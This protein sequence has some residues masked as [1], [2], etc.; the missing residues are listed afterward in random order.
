MF[1]H[2][3]TAL[4]GAWL[5]FFVNGAV[6]S[7]WAPR[8]PSVAA[9]LRLPDSELGIALL[10]VAAG[11]MPALLLT[12]RLLR[13]VSETRVSLCSGAVF[14]ALLPSLALAENLGQLS[15]A[16]VALGA[17]GGCLDVAM[18]TL[19]IRI[20]HGRTRPV[21]SRLHGGYSLGVLAGATGGL[22]AT[23]LG[24]SVPAHFLLTGAGLLAVLAIAAR[25][26]RTEPGAATRAI[27]PRQRSCGPVTDQ[28]QPARVPNDWSRSR[29]RI[30]MS[31]AVL[32]ISALLVEGLILDWAAVLIARDLGGGAEQGALAITAFSAAMFVSRTVG[33][34]RT[35]RITDARIT[36]GASV[37]IVAAAVVGVGS[38]SSRS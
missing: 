26:L 27:P 2:R 11:S 38:G 37:G 12:P 3:P 23:S 32:A 22:A 30:P 29:V 5:I 17:A 34:R 36:V 31:V 6:L 28:R 33:D 20:Q 25:W 7:S 10:G 16:L 18:N 19:G 21:L 8:I 14:A 15:A 9:A 4:T 1:V 35:D 13:R 24:M